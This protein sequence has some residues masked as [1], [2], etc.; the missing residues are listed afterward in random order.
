MAT[1]LYTHPVC[2]E[3]EMGDYHPERPERLR[4]I[5]HALEA[6]AFQSLE[7]REAPRA[8]VAPIER[9]HKAFYVEGI[10]E[11][12]PVEGHR[13][14]DPDTA[15]C[16][17]SPEAGLRA[18]GAA[19]A[20]VD[21]VF[22]GEL[23]NAFCA[24]RPPGHHAESQQALG[25]CLF[26]NV[27]VSARHARA[28][29]GI[30]RVAVVDFDV[31]HGNGTQNDFWFEPDLFYASSHQ[32]PCY[33]GTGM[34]HE[35]GVEDNVVNVQLRPGAGSKEF[36]AGYEDVILPRL[37]KFAPELLIISAGFDAHKRDP[38]AN[39]MLE[40][41]DYAWVTRE[42]VRIAENCCEGRVVSSLEGGYD[43]EALAD[44]VAAHVSAL[45]GTK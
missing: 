8:E 39:L 20:A 25:F 24:V 41:E 34:E 21:A 14:L 16:P 3:H 1:A 31:H 19:M 32:W 23:R 10:L 40:T 43:L 5:L 44:G 27:A 33:P 29:H 4:A 38:L 12:A 7:R 9:V 30:K 15:L 36:R 22:A 17:V 6:E 35:T 28:S 2:V 13:H 18:A 45:M 11:N 42:L 26:N 37:E